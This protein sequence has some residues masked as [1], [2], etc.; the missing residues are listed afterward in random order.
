MKYSFRL[1][2]DCSNLKS[3]RRFVHVVCHVL[4]NCD[5]ILSLHSKPER[6]WTGM[7][8][9]TSKYLSEKFI[10]IDRI[11]GDIACKISHRAHRSSR[12]WCSMS[13][14][15]ANLCIYCAIFFYSL[16]H[17]FFFFLREIS[18]SRFND[19]RMFTVIVR[20]ELRLSYN[21]NVAKEKWRC[22]RIEAEA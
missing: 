15:I 9:K 6:K 1:N 2:R 5:I 18:R 20:H 10:V 3:A 12:S 14:Y 16:P 4:T 11:A 8:Q 21:L 7:F 19:S 22:I 13:Q 17:F